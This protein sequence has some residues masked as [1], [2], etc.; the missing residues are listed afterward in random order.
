I[1]S[2]PDLTI[3]N[4]DMPEYQ[5][6]FG[7]DCVGVGDVNGDG[8]DDFA[9]SA[10]AG[11]RGEVYLFAG[12]D[13]RT[14]IDYDYEPVIPM[15][16]SLSGNYS[17]TSFSP[18]SPSLST[19]FTVGLPV[20]STVHL[21]IY[22]IVDQRIRTLVVWTLSAGTYHFSWDGNDESGKPVCSGIYFVRLSAGGFEQSEKIILLR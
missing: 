11:N 1:D 9:F 6:R 10:I 4:S 21:S 17:D 20:R 3:H 16:Y 15:W 19:V 12:W 2:I 14:L 13:G 8:I 18:F 5:R 22:N 7:Y